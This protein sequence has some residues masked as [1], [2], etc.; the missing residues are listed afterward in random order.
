[1]PE[2]DQCGA[3]DTLT[4]ACNHCGRQFC[5]QHILPENHNCPGLRD[6]ETHGP[7]FRE[8]SER[9]VIQ[10]VT[11]VLGADDEDNQDENRGP[12][13]APDEPIAS[14][15]DVNPDGSMS[16]T[17]EGQ[18]DSDTGPGRIQRAVTGITAGR[19]YQGE[20]PSCGKWI[21]SRPS[22]GLSDCS[23]CGWQPGFPVLRQHTHR[24]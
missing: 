12:G 3:I 14:S 15:P 23:V 1:M 19:H 9:S 5:P 20:C 8:H 22:R 2:C 21:T 4:H 24:H 18:S 17:D 7:D 6:A 13:S 16:N 11:G 10:S